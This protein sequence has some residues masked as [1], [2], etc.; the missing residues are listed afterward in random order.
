MRFDAGA[1]RIGGKRT[2]GVS[3][4]RDRGF[5]YAQFFGPRDRQRKPP[6]LERAGRVL[7]L[8]FDPKL[9]QT[10]LTAEFLGVQKRC[11]AFSQGDQIGI[12][13]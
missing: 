4:G 9:P 8:V 12:V 3:R 7:P 6:V 11:V 2:A 1:R 5:F 10:K 13:P